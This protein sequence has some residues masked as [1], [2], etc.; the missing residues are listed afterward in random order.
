LSAVHWKVFSSPVGYLN[1]TLC[2]ATRQTIALRGALDAAAPVLLQAA[3]LHLRA[4]DILR[5]TCE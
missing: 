2:V 5:V 1:V 4:A 3:V